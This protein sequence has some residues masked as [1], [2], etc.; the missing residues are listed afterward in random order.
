MSLEAALAE[1]TAAVNALR[2]QLAG[3]APTPVKGS[4]TETLD[5]VEK[6]VAAATKP[7][8]TPKAGK[9]PA[10]PKPTETE[11]P[12]YDQVKE[13]ALAL[14]QTKGRDA[15]VAINAEFKVKNAQELKPEKYAEYLAAIAEASGEGAPAAEAEESLV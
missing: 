7:A 11:G 10:A 8:A 6:N 3:G 5:R 4:V 9:P 12:T 2:A 13:K 15:L 14:A 1:N